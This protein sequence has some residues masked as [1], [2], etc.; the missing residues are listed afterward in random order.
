M[1]KDNLK[2]VPVEKLDTAKMCQ[3]IAEMLETDFAFNMNCRLAGEYEF[4]QKEARLMAHILGSIYTISHCIS[5]KACQTKYVKNEPVTDSNRS[6]E[7]KKDGIDMT[8]TLATK[9]YN[10]GYKAGVEAENKACEEI[11]KAKYELGEKKK[12]KIVTGQDVHDA[13]IKACE[14]LAKAIATAIKQR[15]K[16]D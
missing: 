1:N 2:G 6:E 7:I 13:V 15:R 8:I 9:A 3:E 4:T 16:N 5:C 14:E 11:A 10:D 12:V